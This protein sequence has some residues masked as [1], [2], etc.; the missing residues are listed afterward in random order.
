VNVESRLQTICLMILATVAV[1]AALF[2]LKPVLIPLTLAVFVSIAIGPLVDLQS[3]WL[4]MPRFLALVS[5]L[6]IVLVLFSL[7]TMM[8]SSSL[9]QLAAT[10]SD[11]ERQVNLMVDRVSQMLPQDMRERIPEEDLRSLTRIPTGSIARLLGQTTNAILGV[12]SQ[13]FVVFIFV[14]F[15][16]AGGGQW[17]RQE[18]GIMGE[19]VGPVRRF[20]VVSLAISA[21]TG[22]LVALVLM[23]LGIPLATVF[24]LMAFLLNFIPTIGSIIATLLPLP[25]VIISPDISF[26]V[27]MMALALPGLI[28]LIIGNLIAPKVL[29]DS[30]DLHPVMI[31]SAL[32]FWGTLWGI[33]GMLLATPITAVIKILLE[34]VPSARPV[35][36]LM[37]GRMGTEASGGETGIS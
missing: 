7:V 16:L 34:R 31:M 5:T 25:V 8:L 4:R 33:M 9:N 13:G 26:S 3:Q 2:W 17:S 1:G 10:A 18:T 36:E 19:V 28:Q 30:L 37:A 15:L 14:T 24:G 29:G 22:A 35:A 6:L 27:A 23:V 12:L 11:Y 21:S 32:I 20:L